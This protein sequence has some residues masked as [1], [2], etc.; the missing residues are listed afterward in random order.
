MAAAPRFW[1][2]PGDAKGHRRVQLSGS[3]QSKSRSAGQIPLQQF[4]EEFLVGHCGIPPVGP[5]TATSSLSMRVPQPG[6]LFVVQRGQRPLLVRA[7]PEPVSTGG[8]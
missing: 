5:Q 6:R 4:A 8:I 2:S 1:S 7:V 3:Q